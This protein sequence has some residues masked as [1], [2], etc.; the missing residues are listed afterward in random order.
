MTDPLD[1]LLPPDPGPGRGEPSV[2]IAAGTV[3]ADL[4]KHLRDRLDESLNG[5]RSAQTAG[6]VAAAV[7]WGY[8]DGQVIALALAHR[9]TTEKYGARA[10]R[11]AGRMLAKVRP[12]H[13]HIGK[14]CDR[15]GCRNK[16]PWMTGERDEDRDQKRAAPPAKPMT[17]DEVVVA[18]RRWL[19]LPDPGPLY[20]ILATVAANR[21]RGDPV[22]LLLV[23]APG[24]G[25]TELLN[26]IIRL[27]GVHQAATLTEPALL[28]GT[29]AKDK[30]KGAKGGLLREIGS[31]GIVL[32]KDF[33]SVLSMHRDS[34]ALVLAALR[35][36]Y[37]GSW[38]RH[39]GV[40]G[41]RK[42]H[43]D[44]KVGI[45]GGV[46]P[47]IDGHH[48]VMAGLGERFALYRL[49]A[50]DERTQARR[51]IAHAG[52]EGAMRAELAEAVAG[53]FAKVHLPD[54]PPPLQVTEQ[55]RLIDLATLA[56]CCRS[57]VERD[58]YNR[59]VELIPQPEA[60]ARLALVLLR[61]LAGLDAIGVERAEAW[62]L[63]TKVAL[64]SMPA[65]RR[66]VL[67]KLAASHQ[68]QTT[69]DLATT[70][71]YPTT[72]ARR[73]LEDLAAHGVLE[74]T[75]QG[76]GKADLWTLSTWANERWKATVPAMSGG[77]KSTQHTAH[78]DSSLGQ[79]LQK[80]ERERSPS[81]VPPDIAGTVH[82]CPDGDD[83]PALTDPDDPRTS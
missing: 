36:I 67:A 43:W 28:S 32:C 73:A 71:G 40:D 14:P 41:G 34:R 52:R 26:S 58:R 33:G 77:K 38:T 59:E 69:T 50:V 47:S 56:V 74:H 68:P 42:L 13:T 62:R 15:A 35:E 5:D 80:D 78:I 11:E 54:V 31:F 27:A 3:P 29:P 66:T 25:K 37:D 55:D 75:S 39:L 53:L 44:G 46:T 17:L 30:A 57:A 18:F 79:D 24:S 72:T 64:D 48:A 22:W 9:P 6:L 20:L 2:T 82:G 51:A 45:I 7:K 76:K 49:E 16:P 4:P 70:V 8:D 81:Y 21:M 65:L 12:D 1:E 23:G 83:A 10:D 19:D 60:P 61:L 63:V